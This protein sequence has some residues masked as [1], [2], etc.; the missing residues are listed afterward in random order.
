MTDTGTGTNQP[1]IC[2]AE[3]RRAARPLL[4][5]TDAER[6]AV[7][8]A[9]LSDIVHELHHGKGSHDDPDLPDGPTIDLTDEEIGGTGEIDLSALAAP[10]AETSMQGGL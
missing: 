9:H 10:R 6:T 8:Q 7:I 2:E 1:T 5:P 4:Q 3:D